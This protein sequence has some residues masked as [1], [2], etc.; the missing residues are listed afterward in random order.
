MVEWGAFNDC[1]PYLLGYTEKQVITYEDA[2]R[3]SRAVKCHD[4]EFEFM[5]GIL[6]GFMV[7]VYYT[8]PD[9]MTGERKG[10]HG[11]WWYVDKTESESQFVQTLLKACLTSAEH[12]VR[13]G[14]KYNGRAVYM[15]HYDVKKLWDMQG[16]DR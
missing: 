10:Q 8:E 9:T 1:W 2:V 4:W 13:E 12:R 3:I 15:P 14:F 6:T 7:R 5:P 16:V 11:R